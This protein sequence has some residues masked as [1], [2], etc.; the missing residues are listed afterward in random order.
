LNFNQLYTWIIKTLKGEIRVTPQH[1]IGETEGKEM[2]L[3]GGRWSRPPF[4][5]L[6]PSKPG[7]DA[8]IPII[9][10]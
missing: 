10:K 1:A 2:E 4:A 5:G 8:A 3:D 9:E 7:K 6:P